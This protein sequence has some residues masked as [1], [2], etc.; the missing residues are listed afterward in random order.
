MTPKAQSD[1][2]K[3]MGYESIWSR[4]T[5]HQCH[6]LVRQSHQTFFQAKRNE[7]D[8]RLIA[9]QQH[10]LDI[11]RV[12]RMLARDFPEGARRATPTQGQERGCA[13]VSRLPGTEVRA[14][15]TERCWSPSSAHPR[16]LPL[17]LLGYWLGE[18][19]MKQTGQS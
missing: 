1:A 12:R 9:H 14:W 16:Y 18:G 13:H 4:D 15:S 17:L 10:M 3:P 7:T 11:S 8:P 2:Q 6:L 5:H 19:T